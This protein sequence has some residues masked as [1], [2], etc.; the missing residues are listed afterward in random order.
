M[1]IYFQPPLNADL[2]FRTLN[3]GVWADFDLA[4]PPSSDTSESRGRLIYSSVRSNRNGS[5]RVGKGGPILSFD[6]LNGAIRLHT[7]TQ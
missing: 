1:D 2:K 6:G 3:G 7:K 5:G 4:P